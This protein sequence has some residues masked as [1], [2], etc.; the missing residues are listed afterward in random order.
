MFLIKEREGQENERQQAIRA[1]QL[2]VRQNTARFKKRL[3]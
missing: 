3:Q 2:T 1:P